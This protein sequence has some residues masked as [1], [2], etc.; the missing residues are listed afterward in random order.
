MDL[1]YAHLALRVLL[2]LRERIEVKAI[3]VKAISLNRSQ[4]P[5]EQA[6]APRGERLYNS[7]ETYSLHVRVRTFTAFSDE[8]V[9]PCRHNRQRHRAEL[10]HRI[11]E[12]ADVEFRSER[13]LRFS[14]ARTIASVRPEGLLRYLRNQQPRLTRKEI[15]LIASHLERSVKAEAHSRSAALPSEPRRARARRD[16]RTE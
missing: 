10:E 8:A 6:P 15:E 13:L 4:R 9:D 7:P 2:F 1:F 16:S 12:R 14:R 3:I 11:V 5:I